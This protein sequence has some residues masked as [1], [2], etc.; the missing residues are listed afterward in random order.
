MARVNRETRLSAARDIIRDNPRLSKEAINARLKESYSVGLRYS[1]ILSEKREIT[2]TPRREEA[3]QPRYTPPARE[4]ERE[5]PSAKHQQA[6]PIA[7]DRDKRIAK[8]REIIRNEPGL[9]KEEISEKLKAI[10]GVELRYSV[11]LKEKRGIFKASPK[12]L[13]DKNLTTRYV[14]TLFGSQDSQRF[15]KLIKSKVWTKKESI[16]LSKLSLTKIDYLEDMKKS[17]EG[18]ITQMK[19]LKRE[20][21]WSAAEYKKQLAAAIEAEY[22]ERKWLSKDG[23][24]EIFRQ[25]DDYRLSAIESGEYVPPVS[26]NP[27]GTIR[28]SHHTS[29]QGRRWK[30]AHAQEISEQRANYRHLHPDRIRQQRRDYRDKIK[31]LGGRIVHGRTIYP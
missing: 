31:S 14:K 15:D 19:L 27:D 23:K 9:R 29:A 25:L 16:A 3:P 8:A 20:N 12:L 18:L 17:R 21:H 1:V 26:K 28:K 7:P 11:I 5:R 22:K 4:R 30:H 6:T 2:R 13:P 10:F 24:P